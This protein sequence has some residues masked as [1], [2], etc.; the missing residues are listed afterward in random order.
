MKHFTIYPNF[1]QITEI[2]TKDAEL[3][4]SI[5]TKSILLEPAVDYELE[6]KNTEF[7]KGDQVTVDSNKTGILNKLTDNWVEIITDNSLCRINN[8]STIER[9]VKAK[10]NIIHLQS[11]VSKINLTYLFQDVSWKP[12]Y[13]VHIHTKTDKEY[14]NITLMADI[15]TG[16]RLEGN[17]CLITS[18]RKFYDLRSSVI[19]N[20]KP[21]I[22]SSTVDLEMLKYYSHNIETENIVE[23]GY[24]FQTPI[25]LP[26][27]NAYT[28]VDGKYFG[29]FNI[30]E[31][32]ENKFVEFSLGPTHLLKC[33]TTVCST[34]KQFK[35]YIVNETDLDADLTIK[36]FINDFKVISSTE[37]ITEVKKIGLKTCLEWD[38]EVEA[39]N[40]SIFDVTLDLS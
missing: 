39:N 25:Y 14:G 36:Y 8:Y 26:E 33:S 24:S 23:K 15:K 20:N 28:Y 5:D 4:D 9:N 31:T 32:Y 2:I 6:L 38:M 22:L 12:I 16:E 21:I 27:G 35:T 40:S 7:S 30:P 3:L 37:K 10:P 34:G 19:I 1:G 17:F 29:L 13:T 18:E 11:S